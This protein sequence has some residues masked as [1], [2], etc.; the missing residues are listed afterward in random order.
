MTAL[1]GILSHQID[2]GRSCFGANWSPDRVAQAPGRIELIGGHLDYNGG[3]VLA[4]AIDKRIVCTSRE[5]GQSQVRC[6]FPDFDASAVHELDPRK[7]VDW[8]QQGGPIS[9]ADFAR[10][11]I[12]ALMRHRIAL[13]TG[14]D[15]V[16]SGDLPHG[17]GISSS[18]ALCVSLVLALAGDDISQSDLVLLA[19]EAEN[20][21]GSPCGTM[22]QSASVFGQ[23]IRFDGR[24][25]Q[26]S[27]LAVDLG[28]HEFVV[29]NSG[30]VRNLATSSY[31][32]R[33]RESRSALEMLRSDGFPDLPDLAALA[34]SDLVSAEAVLDGHPTLRNRVLHIVTETERVEGA[35]TA[36]TRGDWEQFG[37]IMTAGGRSSSDLYGIG[38]PEVDALTALSLNQPGVLGARIMGGGE[39]GAALLLIR[40]E[41][42]PAIAD[43]LSSGFY[44]PRGHDPENMLIRCHLAPGASVS[45]ADQDNAPVQRD[46]FA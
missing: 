14:I 28:E 26:V 1:D 24:T 39:G 11:A 23:L 6:V 34:T 7:L 31:P 22:D 45:I 46:A 13:R 36:A 19:Q 40:T 41:A 42:W 25:N 35:M 5:N 9:P 3:P 17:V 16:A 15:I 10:G 32:E 43:A 27:P 18:A 33:V 38:H 8:N 37:G 44:R 2:I 12:A 4:A 29:A 30:V 20:R 21:T